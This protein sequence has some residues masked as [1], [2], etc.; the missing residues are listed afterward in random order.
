M[1]KYANLLVRKLATRSAEAPLD[2]NQWFEWVRLLL[3]Q[4]PKLT[5]QTTLDLISDIV[6]SQP[7]NALER[8]N[9]SPWLDIL[10]ASI[11]SQVWYV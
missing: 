11:Q 10:T 7:A 3:D 8:E 6:C 2:L 4:H 9:A 1:I 5:V